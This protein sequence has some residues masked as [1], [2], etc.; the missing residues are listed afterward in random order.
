MMSQI[1][2][3]KTC[4]EGGAQRLKRTADRER[5]DESIV[6][7][8]YYFSDLQRSSADHWS[9]KTRILKMR[10]CY[11]ATGSQ[12]PPSDI[13]YSDLAISIFQF[14]SETGGNM[15]R[16][17]DNSSPFLGGTI[18]LHSPVCHDGPLGLRGH[19]IRT[20]VVQINVCGC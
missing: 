19:A 11:Q 13:I 7:G 10:S 16:R 17:M 20:N 9:S 6:A 15:E 5:K 4:L 14:R 1:V 3:F 18:I 2:E 8:K 12:H